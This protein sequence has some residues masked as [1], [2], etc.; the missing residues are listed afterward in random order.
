M[1][2][3][4]LHRDLNLAVIRTSFLVAICDLPFFC[5]PIVTG[6]VS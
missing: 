5:P 6:F 4:T 3:Q 1:S 2:P